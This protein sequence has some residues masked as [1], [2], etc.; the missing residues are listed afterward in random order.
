MP[1]ARLFLRGELSYSL[2]DVSY[3]HRRDRNIRNGLYH[4][5][6]PPPPPPHPPPPLTPPPPPFPSRTDDFFLQVLLSIKEINELALFRLYFERDRV[7]SKIPAFQIVFQFFCKFD[8]I[9]MT[10]IGIF[11]LHPVRSHL[12]NF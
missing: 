6:P 8:F 9:R 3:I 2:Y 12:D 1:N 4:P 7:Y 11:C 5:P 10:L